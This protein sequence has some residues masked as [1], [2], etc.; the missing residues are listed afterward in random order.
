MEE[1][2]GSE[3]AHRKGT[4]MPHNGHKKRSE[5]GAKLPLAFMLVFF[6]QGGGVVIG[7]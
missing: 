2:K 6:C 4:G 7:G 3:V 1:K 5:F